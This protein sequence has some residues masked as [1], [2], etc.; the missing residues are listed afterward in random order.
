MI[1]AIANHKGGTGKTT[2][3]VNLAAALGELGQRVLVLDMDPQA[4]ATVCLGVVVNPGEPALE[5]LLHDP[6]LPL[7][8]VVRA[9]CAP[10]VELIPA[11][12]DLAAVEPQLAKTRET[13]ALRRR[14]GELRGYDWVL[15]DCPPSL[16]QL[17]LAALAAADGVLLVVD[18]G[19]HA[20]RGLANLVSL[21]HSLPTV[22]IVGV[23]VNEF[24]RRTGVSDDMLTSV[25]EYF[26]AVVFRTVIPRR[27]DIER[28]NNVGQPVL[29]YAPRSAAAEAYRELAGEVV[30][31]AQS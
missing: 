17:T 20:V 5:D 21:L 9:T 2:T 6:A 16:G 27:S 11:T 10:G 25:T 3:A 12:I 30:A 7:A 15:L 1:L 29:H 18:C 23:L 31:R 14:H 4:H 8:A 26:G 28:A 24:D 19:G 22:K 13:D